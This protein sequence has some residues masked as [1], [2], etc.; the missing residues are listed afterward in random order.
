MKNVDTFAPAMGSLLPAALC[1]QLLIDLV[2]ESE[3]QI[4]NSIKI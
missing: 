4:A 1:E 3:L 2:G